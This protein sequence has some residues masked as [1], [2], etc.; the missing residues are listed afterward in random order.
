M[1]KA[2]ETANAA[3]NTD[4]FKQIGIINPDK[5]KKKPYDVK[6]KNFNPKEP[7][8]KPNILYTDK[9]KY[10]RYKTK[11]EPKL[12]SKIMV[13]DE[14][15][16]I[17]KIRKEF[18]I[19]DKTRKNY[20]EVETS[21]NPYYE[22]PNPIQG[23]QPNIVKMLRFDDSE[24][25]DL[26]RNDIENLTGE[27]ITKRL[28]LASGE[29]IGDVADE[30]LLPFDDV[31]APEPFEYNEKIEN[32]KDEDLLKSLTTKRLN[33]MSSDELNKVSIE[34]DKIASKNSFTYAGAKPKKPEA[35]LRRAQDI[36]N[37]IATMNK[38][39]EKSE[40]VGKK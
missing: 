29:D 40:V 18:G 27:I 26:S 30:D 35:I 20:S 4:T 21:G 5:T 7:K 34:L 14:E 11:T 15:D 23:E 3:T 17:A 10:R 39:A 8:I 25:T 33:R 12:L 9:Q 37:E 1:D 13:D 28:T 22:E 16:L 2:I 38:T 32:F 24:I 31:E 6:I 36:M 19:E